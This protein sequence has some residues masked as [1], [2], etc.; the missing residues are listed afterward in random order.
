M[1]GCFGP[2]VFSV[3]TQ[4][5]SVPR[6]GFGVAFLAI[7]VGTIIF[8][9]IEFPDAPINVTSGQSCIEVDCAN[10]GSVATGAVADVLD[11]Q[12]PA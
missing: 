8:Y 5:T 4:A 1:S 11:G 12:V 10:Y 9:T 3:I 6:A 2:L 7:I